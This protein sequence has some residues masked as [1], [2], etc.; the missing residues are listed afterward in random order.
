MVVGGDDSE[1]AD[2]D[3]DDDMFCHYDVLGVRRLL[4]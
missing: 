4:G 3:D 1:D 2:D